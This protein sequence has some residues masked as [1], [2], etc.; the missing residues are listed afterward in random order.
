METLFGRFPHLAEDIYGLLNGKTLS[1]CSQINTQWKENLK[2]YRFHLVKKIRKLLKNQSI[3][4]GPIKYS[5]KEENRTSYKNPIETLSIS[6][7]LTRIKEHPVAL[8]RNITV[9]QLPRSDLIKILNYFCNYD[10]V[11]F[12]SLSSFYFLQSPFKPESDQEPEPGS[13]FKLRWKGHHEL[14]FEA[15][16]D[17]KQPMDVTLSCGDYKV[18]V[19]KQVLSVCS[20]YFG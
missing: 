10:G 8:E 14:F 2:E 9:E 20:L 12:L 13:E 11:F 4:Y 3:V 18:P 1:C 7:W 15:A 17:L 16:I 5:D 19:H 6:T